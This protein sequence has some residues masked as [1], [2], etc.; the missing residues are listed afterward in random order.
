M[1]RYKSLFGGSLIRRRILEAFF[2]HPGKRGHVRQVARELGTVASAVGRELQQLEEAGVLTS[3][4]VGRA[5]VYRFDEESEIARDV[6][7]LFDKTEGIEAMLRRALTGMPGVERALL[8]GSHA[9]RTDRAGSDLDVL[10]VGRPSQS[11]LSEAL[12]PL[13]ERLGRSIH[14]TSM[15]SEEFERRREGSGFVSSVLNGPRI[16]LIGDES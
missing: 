8:F 13:E 6:R 11:S 12:M 3:D 7:T 9:G 1:H 5:R 10:I 16:W 14:T 4:L 2:T 15:S